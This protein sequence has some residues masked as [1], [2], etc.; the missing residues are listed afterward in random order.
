M[1]DKNPSGAVWITLIVAS[2]VLTIPFLFIVKDIADSLR[3]VA[4][5]LNTVINPLPAG[6]PE[7]K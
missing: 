1:A 2:A 5:K 4:D 6:E 3:I 7:T